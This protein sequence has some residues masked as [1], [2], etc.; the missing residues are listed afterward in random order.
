[1]RSIS[2]RCIATS[3]ALHATGR[4]GYRCDVREKKKTGRLE[5]GRLSGERAASVGYEL[6]YEKF[7][8]IVNTQNVT[9]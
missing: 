6:G 8:P 4:S 2:L 7:V 1:M 5:T 9:R 3:I